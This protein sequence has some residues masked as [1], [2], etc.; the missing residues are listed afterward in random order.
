MEFL[1]LEGTSEGPLVQ[2]PRNEQGLA[3][4]DQ[5]A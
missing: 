2:L 3:L 4:I 1:E 5:V